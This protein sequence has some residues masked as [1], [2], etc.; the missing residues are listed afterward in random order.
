MEMEVGIK[1]FLSLLDLQLGLEYLRPEKGSLNRQGRGWL[2]S[3]AMDRA[4]FAPLL[5]QI[6]ERVG[7]LMPAIL[8]HVLTALSILLSKVTYKTVRFNV[9]GK[10]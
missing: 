10:W 8:L 5:E 9:N 7:K 3:A 1:E 2:G 6:W 4:F